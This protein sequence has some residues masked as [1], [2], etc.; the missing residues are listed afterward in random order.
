MG[1]GRHP[2]RNKE[3]KS[4]MTVQAR[5]VLHR[6][7]WDAALFDMDGVLT[8]TARLHIDA[9]KRLFDDFLC[10]QAAASGEA[11]VPFDTRT[12][13]LA[14]V[15]GRPREDGVRLFFAS[16][17]IKLPEGSESDPEDAETVDARGRPVFLYNLLDVKRFVWAGDELEPG[18]HT[19]AFDFKFDG[20]GF[21]KGGTG[22]LIVDGKPVDTKHID[23]AV[24]FIFQW[25]ETFD[26][27]MDTGTPV[28]F[29]D[30]HYDVPFRFTGK[31]N[32]LTFGL[33]PQQMTPDE[34]K[35]MA[36]KGQRDNPASE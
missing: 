28:A 36:V 10:R 18:R 14:Y 32:K 20:G 35:T 30:Y 25:D 26:V 33:G 21:G 12:D 17:G 4:A 19:L 23:H 2:G 22:T 8:D 27:G 16:R 9:W 29:L 3:R 1:K 7:D 31:L 24:P 11:S 34:Q 15:D 13:Y 6:C 5:I